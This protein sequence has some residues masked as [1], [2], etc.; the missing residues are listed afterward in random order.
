VSGLVSSHDHRSAVKWW[1][2]AR[3]FGIR[4]K[5]SFFDGMTWS[6]I[7]AWKREQERKS[8]YP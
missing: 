2:P 4:H 1:F 5:N 6:E 3:F 7:R 8:L